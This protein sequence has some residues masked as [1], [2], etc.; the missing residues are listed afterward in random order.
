MMRAESPKI[1]VS[2]FA[3]GEDAKTGKP[4]AIELPREAAA[5]KKEVE[6]GSSGDGPAQVSTSEY[7]SRYDAIFGDPSLN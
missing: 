2:I 7:L 3:L 1:P 4:K 5:F 6:S